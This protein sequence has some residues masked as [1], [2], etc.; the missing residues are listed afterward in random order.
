MKGCCRSTFVNGDFRRLMWLLPP[1]QRQYDLEL[2]VSQSDFPD[3]AKVGE[4][5]RDD[6]SHR[7][8]AWWLCFMRAHEGRHLDKFTVKARSR[9]KA[10]FEEFALMHAS[11]CSGWCAKTVAL[12][13]LPGH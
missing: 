1:G 9:G 6:G 4:A 2:D 10:I 3:C 12:F 5:L 8:L 13:A 11:A 7:G